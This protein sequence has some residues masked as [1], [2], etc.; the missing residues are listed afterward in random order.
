MTECLETAYF[1]PNDE[2]GEASVWTACLIVL[3]GD[4]VGNRFLLNKD[5]TSIG[6]AEGVDIRLAQDEAVSRLHAEI[7]RVEGS[8][9]FILI[10]KNSANGTLVNSTKIKITMLKDQDLI[11][12]SDHILKFVSSDSPEQAHYDE[13]YRQAHIDKTLQIYDKNYFLTKLGE[14]INYCQRYNTELS[15]IMFDIDFFKK[16]NDTYG[17]L[18]GDAVLIQ[19]V[20]IVKQRIRDTDI[21][22][23]YGG[24]EFAIIMP[25][26]NSEQAYVLAE[27]IRILI[28]KTQ[29]VCVNT[30]VNTTISLGI[31][32]Y[33]MNT[34]QTYTSELLISEADKALYQAKHTGRNKT[35]LFNSTL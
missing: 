35:R 3:Q 8:E 25:Y 21:L 9:Q 27:D 33:R 11:V 29:V 22:C 2:S 28:A 13:L 12:I 23:R 17:H 4:S 20:E 30:T 32:C 7:Q 18:A 34:T 5:L 26:I 6:R 15:L 14:E 19:L 16:I 24:E 31:A 1:I 10:D